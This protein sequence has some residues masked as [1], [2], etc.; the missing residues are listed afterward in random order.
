MMRNA[1]SHLKSLYFKFFEFTLQGIDKI[2]N[3][4]QNADYKNSKS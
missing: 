1:N 3:M 4:Y 2:F